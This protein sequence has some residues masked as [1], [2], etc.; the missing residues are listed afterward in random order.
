MNEKYSGETD[1]AILLQDM[2]PYLHEGEYVFCTV[3]EARL[4]FEIQP[5]SIFRE[6]EGITLILP[7]QQ[8]D[9][10]NLTYSFVSAWITLTIHSALEAV[11][12]TAAIAQEL[13]RANIS[14]NVVA[15]YYHDHLFIPSNDA[16]R[17]MQV[18][19]QMSQPSNEFL[20]SG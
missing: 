18:L 6:A 17:A 3:Q 9:E 16:Q 4:E 8:A 2:Q 11:G 14:C 7:K 10:L 20:R 1:L 12:L 19:N 15:A 13:A 5:L